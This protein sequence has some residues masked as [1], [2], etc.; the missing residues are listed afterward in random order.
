MSFRQRW[1]DTFML[2]R[3]QGPVRTGDNVVEQVLPCAETA[4]TITLLLF[5][6][7]SFFL[8]LI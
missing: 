5:S 2:A 7:S 6:S 1:A 4:T 3:A 8:L